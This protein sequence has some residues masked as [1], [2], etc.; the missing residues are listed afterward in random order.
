MLSNLVLL[1]PADFTTP[2][3]DI[4]LS[5]RS[6]QCALSTENYASLGSLS[7]KI[8]ANGVELLLREVLKKYRDDGK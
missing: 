7:P 2:V 8:F 3:S 1:P 5:A 4:Y 6:I